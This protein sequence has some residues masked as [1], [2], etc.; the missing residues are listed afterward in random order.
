MPTA[1]VTTKG[2]VTIPRSIRQALKVDAGDPLDFILDAEGLVAVRP[3]NR[4]LEEIKGLLHDVRRKPVTVEEMNGEVAR[5]GRSGDESVGRQPQH[6]DAEGGEGAHQGRVP[7][8][9]TEPSA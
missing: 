1:K 5:H 2:R 7:S 8:S 6:E 3:A 9:H 4:G